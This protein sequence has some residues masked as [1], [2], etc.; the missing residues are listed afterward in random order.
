MASRAALVAQ[1][2]PAMAARG[3]STV[4]RSYGGLVI[5]LAV[6]AILIV[7]ATSKRGTARGQEPPS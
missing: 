3:L 7:T 6:T 4:T 5:F 2:A 1:L